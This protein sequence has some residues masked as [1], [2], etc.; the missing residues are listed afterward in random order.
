MILSAS[1]VLTIPR[2]FQKEEAHLRYLN[3]ALIHPWGEKQN[4]NNCGKLDISCIK[5]WQLCLPRGRGAELPRADTRLE[6]IFKMA[7]ATPVEETS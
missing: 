3:D 7:D 6:N 2:K 5:Q 4:K 1:I